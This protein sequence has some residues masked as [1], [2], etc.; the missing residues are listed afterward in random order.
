LR[1]IHPGLH[2]NPFS[3]AFLYQDKYCIERLSTNAGTAFIV[4]DRRSKV[5]GQFS[6][7][8]VIILHRRPINP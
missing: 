8:V 3:A 4:D 7:G 6:S 5:L 2:I 1:C